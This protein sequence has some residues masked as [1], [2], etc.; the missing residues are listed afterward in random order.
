MAR[1]AEEQKQ[2]MRE[3]A[4]TQQRRAATANEEIDYHFYYIIVAHLFF[5]YFSFHYSPDFNNMQF[6]EPGP[7]FLPFLQLLTSLNKLI[8]DF[9]FIFEL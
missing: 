7:R 5:V 4:R 9:F 2:P 6:S 1:N 3:S 8:A